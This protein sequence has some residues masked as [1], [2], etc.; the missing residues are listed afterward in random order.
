MKRI[1]WAL[2]ATA[3]YL[4][5]LVISFVPAG[6]MPFAGRLTGLL[7]FRLLPGRRR[8]AVD[9][10]RQALPHMR[11][12]PEWS[13]PLG[14]P[15]EIARETFVHLGMSLVETCRVYRGRGDY[16]IEGIEFR[17]KEHYDA[18]RARGKGLIFL[19]GHCGNWELGALAYGRRLQSSI[20]VVARRQDNPY[21]NAMV[22][23]I[24]MRYE[25]RVIYKENALRS[26]LSVIKQRST[27]GLLVDQA[28]FPDE[29]VM[30]P[31]LGR[32]A[33]ASK[34]PVVL[35]RKTGVAVLP[36][37]VHREG[38]RNVITIYPECVFT[39]GSTDEEIARDVKVYSECIERFIIDH[40]ADWYWVHRRWKRAGETAQ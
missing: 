36:A 9:N 40:P 3:F 35:S 6:L 1:S 30:I 21:L 11:S 15:E 31:F 2:Q 4:F 38:D 24:R 39:G 16:L 18:A 23:T 14:T 28:V 26:M 12:R 27:I 7:M 34:A 10:I 19:T 33:W 13:C 22:E 37:F 25:N 32:M 17:G 5:T 20:S 8:V 29:G